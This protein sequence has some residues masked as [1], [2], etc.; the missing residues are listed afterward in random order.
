MLTS[1]FTAPYQCSFNSTIAS[2]IVL[3]EDPLLEEHKEYLQEKDAI[4]KDH[5]GSATKIFTK[6]STDRKTVI[7][8]AFASGVPFVDPD[9]LP[10]MDSLFKIGYFGIFRPGAGALGGA[11]TT[12][13]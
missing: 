4:L 11:E 5:I 10:N 8:Q 1:E 9:F 12:G 6:G 7:Q 3:S 13:D 2:L